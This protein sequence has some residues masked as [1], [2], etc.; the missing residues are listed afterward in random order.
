MA[1]T[2]AGVIT[3]VNSARELARFSRFFHPFIIARVIST[4]RESRG[5]SPSIV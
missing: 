1:L 2:L 5:R 4:Q 3:F